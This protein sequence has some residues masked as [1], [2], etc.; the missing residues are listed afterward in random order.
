MMRWLTELLLLSTPASAEPATPAPIGM[1]LPMAPSAPPGVVSASPDDLLDL[2]RQRWVQ[3]D[4]AGVITLLTPWLESRTPRG[5]TR[6]AANLL[7]GVAQLDL[8]NPNIASSHFYAVRRSGGPLAEYGA[9]YEA[10][11]DHRRGRHLVAA[12]ECASYRKNWPDAFYADECLVLMGDAYGAAGQTSSAAAAYG[13]YLDDH[14]DSPR[15]EELKLA[16]VLALAQHSP[17]TAIP[18]LHELMLSHIYPST[19]LAARSALAR[20]GEAGFDVALP[21]DPRSRMR[22]T[23]SLRRSG[24]FIASWAEFEALTELGKTNASVA[25]W[26][27]NN[28]SRMSWGNRR[29][30]VYAALYAEKYA[31]KPDAET[32]WK[33]FR[34]YTRQGLWDK[35]AE[36]GLIAMENHKT[37]F[38][39]RNADAQIARAEM[40]SGDFAAASERYGTISGTDAKFYAA[41]CAYKSEDWDLAQSRFDLVIQGGGHWKAAGYYWRAA[42]HDALELPDEAAADRAAAIDADRSGWYWL[43]QQPV[44]EGEGWVARNGRW[45][46]GVNA[47]LPTWTVPEPAMTTAT[48]WWPESFPILTIDGKNRQGLTTPVATAVD[49]SALKWGAAPAVE[50]SP[51]PVLPASAVLSQPTTVG[52][53]P[54]GYTACKWFDPDAAMAT[55]YRAAEQSRSQWPELRTTYD[56]ANAGQYGEAAR[57]LGPLYKN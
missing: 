41:F 33:I 50:A 1:V 20:L 51:P 43:L 3:G 5:R 28:E 14:P 39:W 40:L 26:V 57:L 23:D 22:R 16:H 19:D 11:S 47:T 55:L 30:D 32:A 52:G 12:R 18:R 56:L 8:G 48:G 53:L 44:P 37:H 29:Y 6:D 10:V 24:Q 15:E 27:T 54:D 17:T 46:G 35:A 25:T 45:Q 36:I 42:V 2:A 13:T 9:W 38:R 21:D 4:A 7:A 49:W 34:A 31:K